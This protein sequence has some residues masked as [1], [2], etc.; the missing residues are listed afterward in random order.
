VAG[1]A[2]A[3]AAM[4]PVATNENRHVLNA[5]TN[6]SWGMPHL[7]T[8]MGNCTRSGSRKEKRHERGKSFVAPRSEHRGRVVR[9]SL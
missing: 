8:R 9:S 4:A 2:L 7:E 5:R 3:A 1:G 6:E